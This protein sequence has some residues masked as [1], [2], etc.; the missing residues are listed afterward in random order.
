MAKHRKPPRC[1]ECGAEAVLMTGKDVYPRNPE[2]WDKP[3]WICWTPGCGARCGCHPGTTKPLGRP[4]GAALRRA[5][6]MLHGLLDPIWKQADQLSVY[7][8]EDNRT[9]WQIRGRAR[10]R[11][12][13]WLRE[14]MGLTEKECHVGEFSIEQC[15]EAWRLLSGTDYAAIREWAKQQTCDP[16]LTS[17]PA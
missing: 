9:R 15:R 11:V 3:I 1:I 17:S 7:A 16:Y 12:Y 8:P 5:R 13:A 10:K 6:Q 2:F 14:R 4:A